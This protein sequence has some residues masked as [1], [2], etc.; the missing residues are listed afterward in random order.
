M[1]ILEGTWQWKLATGPNR[2]ELVKL[3]TL[4][5]QG[6]RRTQRRVYTCTQPIS[7][8]GKCR[9]WFCSLNWQHHD[10]WCDWARLQVKISIIYLVTVRNSVMTKD[11]AHN[12]SQLS[13]RRVLLALKKT[14][15][16]LG[17]LVRMQHP[18]G[19]TWW[20]AE[21]LCS[22]FEGKCTGSL[23]AFHS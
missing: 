1:G 6:S 5:H 23:K 2:F 9:D 7:A 4:L 20:P 21:V 18:V 10:W 22:Y 19:T 3:F 16:L 17:E 11:C 12:R 15:W 14:K 13:L 8:N